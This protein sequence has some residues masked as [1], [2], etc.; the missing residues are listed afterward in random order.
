M[1]YTSNHLAPLAADR[2]VQSHMSDDWYT[3]SVRLTFF[4]VTDWTQRQVFSEITGIAPTQ[5]NAQPPMQVYQETGNLSDA[6]LSV[7]QQG[8]RIDVML[9][10]QP[11]RNTVDPSLPEYKPLYWIGSFTQSIEQFN[12]IAAKTVSLVSGATRVAYAMT[13]VQQTATA[14]EAMISLRKHLPTIDFDPNSDLDL[15]FQINRPTRDQEGRFI[16]RFARWDTI[17]LT[18]VRMAVGG[19][20]PVLPLPSRPPICAARIYVDIS[21]DADNTSPFTRPALSDL[22]DHLRDYAVNIAQ[23]GDSK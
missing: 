13:L 3:E 4:E 17:H 16:N 14:R 12:A 20:P 1:M 2:S 8:S 10:D 11:T 21:T 23:N 5:I 15:A 9:T 19:V 22:V 6:Y 7:A 18:S